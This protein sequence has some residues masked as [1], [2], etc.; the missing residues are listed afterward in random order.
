MY[1]QRKN[2]DPMFSLHVVDEHCARQ[3]A[4]HLERFLYPLCT[5]HTQKVNETISFPS[6]FPSN[7]SKGKAAVDADV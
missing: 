5:K 7:V 6:Q 3:V 2:N 4:E 1:R